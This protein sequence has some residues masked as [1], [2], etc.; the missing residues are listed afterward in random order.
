MMDGEPPAPKLG[1]RVVVQL[2]RK[3]Q[4]YLD[5]STIYTKSRWLFF[6]T[7]LLMY[8]L[9]VYMLDGCVHTHS[10]NNENTHSSVY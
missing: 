4:Q 1:D 10:R 7:S 9:R 5:V 6:L 2:G 3:F 8:M